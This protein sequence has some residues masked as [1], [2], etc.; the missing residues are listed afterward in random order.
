MT[1]TKKYLNDDDVLQVLYRSAFDTGKWTD[2]NEIRRMARKGLTSSAFSYLFKTKDHRQHFD[3]WISDSLTDIKNLVESKEYKTREELFGKIRSSFS[4]HPPEGC[5]IPG[6]FPLQVLT[7]S[8]L[9]DL[10]TQVKP[11]IE[12][13]KSLLKGRKLEVFNFLAK[14]GGMRRSISELNEKFWKDRNATEPHQNAKKYASE[15]NKL[16][17]GSGFQV[18]PVKEDGELWG[19]RIF[20]G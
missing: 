17:K 14:V 8:F 20:T 3:R 4:Y 12:S 5:R 2:V 10:K 6:H 16:I 15:I 11:D 19:Y 1:Q 13:A 18:E 9:D 7:A